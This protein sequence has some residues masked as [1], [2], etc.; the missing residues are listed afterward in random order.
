MT[1]KKDQLIAR[2]LNLRG[3][4]STPPADFLKYSMQQIYHFIEVEEEKIEGA[5]QAAQISLAEAALVG[6]H[7]APSQKTRSAFDDFFGW[8]S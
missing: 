6:G 5:K 7:E 4:D 8:K 1:Q 2:L 3:D